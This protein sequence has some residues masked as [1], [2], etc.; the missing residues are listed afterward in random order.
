MQGF[1]FRGFYT[2]KNGEGEK[3][4]D[5]NGEPCARVEPAS[6]LTLYAFYERDESVF[7]RY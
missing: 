4:I 7:D 1:F 2:E 3:I 5:E 6:E